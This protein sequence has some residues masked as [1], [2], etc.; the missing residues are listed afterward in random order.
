MC[1]INNKNIANIQ[2]FYGF[3]E[4]NTLNNDRYNND[5]DAAP[6]MIII[7]ISSSSSS[8]IS[9]INVIILTYCRTQKPTETILQSLMKLKK[10]RKLMKS[11]NTLSMGARMHEN[12][13]KCLCVAN[14]V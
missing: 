9:V 5:S 2:I 13:V 8:G 3:V 12:A 11:K 1:S 10:T 4:M 14:V 6:M 7:V